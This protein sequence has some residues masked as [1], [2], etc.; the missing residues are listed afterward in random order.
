M[1]ILHRLV[2]VCDGCPA[3]QEYEA[4]VNHDGEAAADSYGTRD[5]CASDIDHDPELPDG[6]G[7]ERQAW[8]RKLL[9]PECRGVSK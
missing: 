8:N 9:C 3:R 2:A 4:H 1:P 6:W 5:L 7:W